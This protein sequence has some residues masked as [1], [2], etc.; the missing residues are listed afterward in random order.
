MKDVH[1]NN[2]SLNTNKKQFKK[3]SNLYSNMTNF[4]NVTSTDVEKIIRT[5]CNRTTSIDPLPHQIFIHCIKS[6]STA[7]D[8]LIYMPFLEGNFSSLYKTAQITPFLKKPNLE[9]SLP[10]NFRPISN[11]PTIS[12]IVKS[13]A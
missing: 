11:L 7:I 2:H 4:E 6:L 8:N 13:V 3:S 9:S 12:K 5:S 10:T 1:K